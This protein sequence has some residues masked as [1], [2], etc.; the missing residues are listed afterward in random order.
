MTLELSRKLH[1]KC[2]SLAVS[3]LKDFLQKGHIAERTYHR[4]DKWPK[5]IK[6]RTFDRIYILPLI[7]R[8]EKKNS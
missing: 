8:Y 3:W 5:I 2:A 1:I 6:K 7:H 4:K